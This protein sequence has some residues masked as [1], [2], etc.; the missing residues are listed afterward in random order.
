MAGSTIWW[1]ATGAAIAVEL[2]TGTFYLLMVAVGLA[3]AALAAH[4]GLDTSAQ[5]VVAAVIGGGAVVGWHLRQSKRPAS[6]EASTNKDVN[7]DIGETVHITA[8]NADGSASVNYRGANWTV[9]H[10]GGAAPSTGTHKVVE[11]V[12]SRLLV[13]KI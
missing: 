13:E 1:L 9:L 8:W 6:P 7:L 10:R 11:V 3:A 12:G 4:A 5:L 2:V